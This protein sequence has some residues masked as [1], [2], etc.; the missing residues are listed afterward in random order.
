MNAPAPKITRWLSAL[1]LVVP[2]AWALPTYAADDATGQKC[3]DLLE[4]NSSSA[5]VTA[6]GVALGQRDAAGN[7]NLQGVSC[8]ILDTKARNASIFSFDY[9][10]PHSPALMLAGLSS[11]KITPATSLKAFVVALPGL[12]GSGATANSAAFDFAPAWALSEQGDTEVLAYASYTPQGYWDR[13]WYRTRVSG[14]ISKGDDGGGDAK[15]AKPSRAAVGVSFSLL[16]GSDPIMARSSTDVNTGGAEETHWLHCLRDN[17]EA[18]TPYVPDKSTGYYDLT[19]ARSLI[20][21][22]LAPASLGGA[23]DV[24]MLSTGNMSIL[25]DL[26]A[27]ADKVLK[28]PAA[29]SYPVAW[30]SFDVRNKDLKQ[31]QTD[32]EGKELAVRNL[33]AWKASEDLASATIEKCS[34]ESSAIAQN[35][36]D[37]QIGAGVVLQGAAGGPNWMD[38]KDPNGAVWLAARIPLDFDQSGTC[39]K[40][41]TGAP[42]QELSCWTFGGTARFSAGEMDATGNAAT[43]FFKA[44]VA[45]GWLGLERVDSISKIGFYFGWTDYAA[46][47]TVG[48]PFAKSGT[49]WLISGAYNLSKV[50]EGLWIVGSYGSANGTLTT[51]DDK[52]AMLSLT[53]AP[54]KIGSGFIDNEN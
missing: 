51:L 20:T 50:Y 8:N 47:E 5:L 52:V 3:S 53:F 27:T 30:N 28:R 36:A 7:P 21:H 2:L 19:R 22:L 42:Q 16:D 37:I 34:K 31:L 1:A 38:F 41:T 24:N 35:G 25:V 13:V 46:A 49:R 43:P 17:F 54:A 4:Q 15:K 11:D 40:A 45:E 9:G 18:I 33:P 29:W 14:A 32:L 39:E 23:G 10:V 44:N 6:L 26:E 12:V 48:K